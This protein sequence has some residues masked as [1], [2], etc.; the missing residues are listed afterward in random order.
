MGRY[1]W[2]E[3]GRDAATVDSA[4]SAL[5]AEAYDSLKGIKVGIAGADLAAADAANQMPWVMANFVAGTTVTAYKDSLL[6]AALRDD[7]CT[8]WPVASSNMIGV[9]GP[10]ANLFA[11]YANDFTDAFYGLSPFAGTAY[12]GKVVPIPCWNRNWPT[13]PTPGYNT[14]ASSSSTGYAVIATHKDINGTVLFNV[15]GHWGRDTYYAS[16]WLHGDDARGL[17]PGIIQLQSAPKG[18]TSI[19]LKINYSPNALHPTY[20]IPEVLGTISER[21]WYHVSTDVTDPNKGGIHDP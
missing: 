3:V 19:I 7:F 16:M 12:N 13:N 17:A 18:V 14:Y 15:W 2:V 5:V 8:Y 4:G 6:R 20:T 21:A 1:E 11:Y 10:L 9:G